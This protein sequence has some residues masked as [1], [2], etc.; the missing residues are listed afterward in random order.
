M[1]KDPKRVSAQHTKCIYCVCAQ[2][3]NMGRERHISVS[4]PRILGQLAAECLKDT[5]Y[6]TSGR[7]LLKLCGT[8]VNTHKGNHTG[9]HALIHL[10]T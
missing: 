3:Q 7:K 4:V 10:Q 5:V 6:L 8:N 2:G 9:R 1:T